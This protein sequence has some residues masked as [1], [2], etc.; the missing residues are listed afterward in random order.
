MSPE[1]PEDRRADGGGQQVGGQGPGDPAG[2]GVELDGE[3]AQR[4]DQR[5][6]GE[7]ERERRH[8][9]DEQAAH[10]MR[11]CDEG[12]GHGWRS[13]PGERGENGLGSPYRS[14]PSPAIVARHARVR[15]RQL[16]RGPSRGHG[17]DRRRQRRPRPPV[18]RRRRQRARRGTHARSLR[19]RRAH[20]PGAQRHGRQR[21][22]PARDAAPMAGRGVR[23]E[24]APQCR[25]VRRAGGDGRDQAAD[26][27]GVR[28]Q[29]HAG[30]GGHAARADR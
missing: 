7:R 8:A 2:V 14:D 13:L 18:R 24:R 15:L 17:G 30:A 1:A 19:R 29:A 25:R 6:L 12:R 23:G 20:V 28:R 26:R 27:P 5:G 21:R 16:R 22:R 3:L 10:G 11:P 4:G 9:Q